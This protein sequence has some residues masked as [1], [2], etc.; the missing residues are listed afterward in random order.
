MALR[1][2][3][4]L[5]NPGESLADMRSGLLAI[6]DS[7]AESFKKSLLAFLYFI[8]LLMFD[9]LFF[10]LLSMYVLYKIT[11]FAMDRAFERGIQSIQVRVEPPS[12]ASSA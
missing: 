1:E 12:E 7:V 5:F 2:R 11:Q 10:P 9:L 8:L 4:S 3:I 6:A